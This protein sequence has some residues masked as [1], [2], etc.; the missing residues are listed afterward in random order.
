MRLRRWFWC[1]LL[2][3]SVM[4]AL[5]SDIKIMLD[6]PKHN[7]EGHMREFLEG[8]AGIVVAVGLCVWEG[9]R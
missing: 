6:S 7:L 2:A 1:S 8:L 3:L 9:R 4:M 5:L